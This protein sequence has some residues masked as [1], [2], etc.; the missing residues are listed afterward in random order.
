MNEGNKVMSKFWN[1]V[2][3][4][5]STGREIF[6]VIVSPILFI[7]FFIAGILAGCFGLIAL[8]VGIPLSLV[9]FIIIIP[10]IFFKEHILME[11][12]DWLERLG[13]R[14]NRFWNA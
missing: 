9:F 10:Y 11:N 5:D 14:W 7:P 13:E 8:V 1:W 2:R 3:Y 4:G 6:L 12:I